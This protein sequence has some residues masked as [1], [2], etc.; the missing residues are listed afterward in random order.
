MAMAGSP[1]FLRALAE[2]QDWCEALG[3]ASA[4]GRHCHLVS[5]PQHPALWSANHASAIRAA[6]AEEID[7]TLE[8]IEAAFSHSPYRVVDADAF[9]PPA[10]L[11]RL[12]LDGWQEQPAVILMVLQGSLPPLAGPALAVDAVQTDADWA[13]LRSLHE[14]DLTEG[15]RTGGAHPAEIAEGLYQVMRKK[16]A[17]G[18]IFLARHAGRASA[19]AMAV[20]AAAGFGLV[21]DVFTAPDLRRR[22]IA[23]ALIAHCVAWLRQQGCG[24]A[25]L[26][27]RA[28][29]R[30]KVLYARL[31]F[32]P[33]MLAHRWVKTMS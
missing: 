21:D 3:H 4:E 31:G 2:A 20:P 17:A 14:L 16:A 24:T 9:T 18:R 32:M 8:D 27:A 28:S 5:D 12:A 29:D 6:S 1:A 33:E 22:G 25:F 30:P 13:E 23:S 15:A 7:E 11:A 26:T 10:F 19:Y